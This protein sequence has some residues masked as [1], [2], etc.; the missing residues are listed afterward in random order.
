MI[1]IKI[2]Y[3]YLLAYYSLLFKLGLGKFLLKKIYGERIIV[4]HGIDVI[5]E[6]KYNSRFHSKS[7]FEAFIKYIAAHYNVIS[8]EDY[9]QKNFKTNTLNIAITFDDGYLNNYNYAVPILEKYSIPATFFI[10]TI[11]KDI[12]YLW[13]DFVDLVSYYSN[14]KSIVFENATYQKNLKNEFIYNG[15][16][17]KNKCKKLS[18]GAIIKLYS[19]FKDDWKLVQYKP[20]E[21]YWE[22]MTHEQIKEISKNALFSIGSHSSTHTNLIEIPIEEAKSE[23]LSSK[24]ILEVICERPIFEFAFPFGNYNAELVLYCKEIGFEKILLVDYNK[25]EDELDFALRNRFVMNPHISL[26]NQLAF[27]VKGSYF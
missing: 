19:E 4:F 8:L 9:Y 11:A 26:K 12:P 14:K 13:P 1:W 15:M 6:T 5:G 20:L 7:F 23:I 18:F 10:T 21:D 22:L 2:K 27:L 24:K 3:R 16:S 17:L 25:K